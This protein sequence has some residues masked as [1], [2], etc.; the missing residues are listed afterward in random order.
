MSA[1]S[2]YFHWPYCLSK[3]PYCDF[4]VHSA[5][6]VDAPRWQSAYLKALDH[7]A[8]LYPQREITSIFFGGGTPSLMPPTMVE[9]IIARAAKLWPVAA[10]CEITLEANPTSTEID[11]FKA[12]RSAGVNRL[13]L[14]VQALNDADLTFLGRT[15]SA[16]S[17]RTA[18]DTA[19]IVFDRFSFDLI[20]ARPQQTLS[21]WEAE[22]RQA[23]A[24][25][26]GHLSLY[27]LT[28]ERNTPF[29][30][31]HARKEFQLPPDDLAA[32]FYLLT[33]EVTAQAGLP[34]YEVSN[35]AAPGHESRHNL[36]YWHY[37]DYL[38]IGP[39]AHGRITSHNG[40]RTAIRDHHAPARWLDWVE[41]RGCGAHE[42]DLLGAWDQG[43]EALMMGLRLYDGMDVRAYDA[44]LKPESMQ[45]LASEGWLCYEEGRLKLTR[46]GMVRL[47]MILPYIIKDKTED[48]T[49]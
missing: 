33:Q 18:I 8:Q 26:G 3:C 21:A 14:G 39:G 31:A 44:F 4:N 5:D 22:L 19:R 46:E 40:A 23:C 27:Q 2:L 41:E 7:Y 6:N 17:A 12:F 13:S 43:L 15:H 34:A 28:V 49:L 35:H 38:G 9:A 25:A 45:H 32:D 47:N 30:L 16:A 24:L 1:L 11:R 10:Q 37:G 42:A 36:V 20:Y 29:Y 48:K